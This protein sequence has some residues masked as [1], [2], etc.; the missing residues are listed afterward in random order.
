MISKNLLN[1]TVLGLLTSTALVLPVVAAEYVVDTPTMVTNGDVAHLLVGNGSLTIE[2]SGSITTITDNTEAVNA[3]GNTNTIVNGGVLS[4]RGRNSEGIF[5]I[6][7]NSI[8]NIG[9]IATAG[10]F[11][12]GIYVFDNNTM[13]N[14][15]TI[16]TAGD[17]SPGI[18]ADENNVIDNTGT[19]S[20]AGENSYG[21]IGGFGNAISNAGVINTA[22]D[23]SFGVIASINNGINNSGTIETAGYG[24]FGMM[25]VLDNNI[26]NTG[27]IL[28]VGNDAV[29]IVA[30][31]QNTVNNSGYVVSV[32]SN[33]FGFALGNTLNLMAPSFIGGEIDMGD[34]ATLN[35]TTGRSQS[36]L[37][38]FD[39][40]DL[41]GPPTIGGEVPWVY[42]AATGT[43]ATLDPTALGAAPDMLA[44]NVGSLSD[45]VRRNGPGDHDN[46]WIRG[47]GGYSRY[48]AQGIFN[49]Y[50]SV[51]GGVAAGGAFVLNDNFSIGAMIGYQASGL[52]VNSA[53]MQSQSIKSQ[54]MVG[55]IYANVTLDRF[56]ADLNLFVGGQENV[57]SRL[58]NDN[59]APLGV[60]YAG[61]NY[62]SWFVAPEVRAGV[63]IASGGI[64]TLT[65][66]ASARISM[67]Q[68][69]SYSE[70]GSSANISIGARQVQLFEGDLELAASRAIENG[71]LT[72]RGGLQYRQ[73]LGGAT[74]DV[75]L[76]GQTLAMPLN[77][78]GALTGYLGGEVS[79][80]VGDMSSFDISASAGM[81]QGGSFSV[82]GSLGYKAQF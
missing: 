7:F 30:L 25:A 44:D 34:D 77:N 63:N 29:G 33:S 68:V 45:L 80:D 36:V 39:P 1:R 8:T 16:S 61:A 50:A 75:V 35:I 23:G 47:F 74:Q 5:A 11:A 18:V 15:G 4:T 19:I 79:L 37:W 81:G 62:G 70:T 14:A 13:A 49:D 48:G 21:I 9:S 65:P 3:G 26:N 2:Q 17:D 27:R 58:V 64:W 22:G 60:S 78:G 41:A 76:L 40:A 32:Q 46:L 56:F 10:D 82:S 54:G 42:D 52:N 51:N 67:Q 24:A 55:G 59:L 71:N 73:M 28:T 53:W 57:S 66:G 31:V 12:A 20:S 72:V 6:D 43:F 69:D 38:Q